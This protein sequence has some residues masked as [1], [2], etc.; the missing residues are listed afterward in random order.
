MLIGQNEFL[1]R[2]YNNLSKYLS[3]IQQLESEKLVLVAA[4]HLDK[5]QRNYPSLQLHIGSGNT[6]PN[7]NITKIATLQENISEII[8]NI[9]AE[10]TEI[11]IDAES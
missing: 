8:E 11:I 7:Y 4:V 1:L 6:D 2:N 9:I 10:K 5:I 3:D